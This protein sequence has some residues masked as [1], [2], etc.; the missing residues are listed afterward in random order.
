MS[1]L[2]T[3]QQRHSVIDTGHPH[4]RSTAINDDQHRRPTPTNTVVDRQRCHSPLTSIRRNDQ[5]TTKSETQSENHNS[6][7]STTKYVPVELTT[8][9]A[10]TDRKTCNHTSF[11]RHVPTV[12][13]P[14]DAKAKLPTTTSFPRHAPT[15][16]PTRT[17]SAGTRP[18]RTS[19]PHKGP[20]HGNFPP[21]LPTGPSR[22]QGR[23]EPSP[24]NTRTSF[25]TR[26]YHA[27]TTRGK[28]NT[29]LGSPLAQH[30]HAEAPVQP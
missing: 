17:N 11:P 16:F 20:S 24:N 30:Q 22:H 12:Q 4:R 18:N 27:Q 8:R 7:Y 13:Y 14:L 2:T 23:R 1:F 15:E 5:I 19:P 28:V 26:T 10:L 21:V 3:K 6:T 25:T 9:T 29:K